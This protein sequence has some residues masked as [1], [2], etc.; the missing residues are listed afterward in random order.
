MN[1]EDIENI[2]VTKPG[3]LDGFLKEPELAR[4]LDK[5][6]QTLRKWRRTGEGPPW[7]NIGSTVV[8]PIDGFRRWLTKRVR[9]SPRR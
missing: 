7:T 8:Y 3:L 5:K 9:T 4:E 2:Q 6:E 1:T